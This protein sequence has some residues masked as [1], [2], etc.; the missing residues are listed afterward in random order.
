MK[1]LQNSTF[2]SYPVSSAQFLDSVELK[3]K[4]YKLVPNMESEVVKLWEFQMLWHSC[5]KVSQ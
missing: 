5:R 4:L 1:T 3:Q 2:F